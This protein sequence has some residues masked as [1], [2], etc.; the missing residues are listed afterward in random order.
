M[1]VTQYNLK[2]VLA[3]ST[4]SQIGLMVMAC[5]LGAFSV[6]MFHLYTHAFFKACL[7]LGPAPYC[8]RSAGEEDMRRMGGLARRMPFTFGVFLLATLALCGL[9]PFAG[10][11]SK[12]EI[13]W[14]AY[15]ATTRLARPVA[16]RAPRPRSSRR[17]TCSAR[18]S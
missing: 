17:S 13:L 3:Y 4:M 10:F 14:S 16:R 9:P 5:G 18:S 11:F 7:F 12:D 2:K 8:T 1:G 15:A 6:G